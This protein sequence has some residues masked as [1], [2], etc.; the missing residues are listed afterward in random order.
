MSP[1]TRPSRTSL[2]DTSSTDL[3][4]TL[5]TDATGRKLSDTGSLSSAP[6]RKDSDPIIGTAS[7]PGG[8]VR[9]TTDDDGEDSAVVESSDDG[10]DSSDWDDGWSAGVTANAAKKKERGRRRTRT[11]S[12]GTDTMGREIVTA[13]G[14]LDQARR[15]GRL[16]ILSISVQAMRLTCS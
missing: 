16:Q 1:G 4:S 15:E 10:S 2:V 9:L 6:G 13:Q 14:L 12:G 3:S 11:E 8:G 5:D 7:A